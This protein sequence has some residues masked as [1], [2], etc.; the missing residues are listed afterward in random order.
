MSLLAKHLK[1]CDA[2]TTLRFAVSISGQANISLLIGVVSG[3]L[4]LEP[5]D[6]QILD[7]ASW[8]NSSVT[9]DELCK[10]IRCQ[11]PKSGLWMTKASHFPRLP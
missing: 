4:N 1:G 3:V 6:L 8:L 9:L 7:A 5:G 11:F 2:I 10:A